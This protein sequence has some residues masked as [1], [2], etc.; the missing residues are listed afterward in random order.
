MLSQ[1]RFNPKTKLAKRHISVGHCS[2]LGK[3]LNFSIIFLTGSL[4]QNVI[5]RWR[6]NSP[7]ILRHSNIIAK[8]GNVCFVL[9]ISFILADKRKDTE[10]FTILVYEIKEHSL[11]DTCKSYAIC[12]WIGL[13]T[14]NQVQWSETSVGRF[15]GI[16]WL[17]RYLTFP[18]LCM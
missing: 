16:A 17:V 18:V 9:C 7:C 1:V 14:L 12:Y 13:P 4:L 8:S 15:E 5:K 11:F 10:K 2:S 3:K 6:H